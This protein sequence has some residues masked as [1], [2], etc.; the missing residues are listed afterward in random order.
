MS[1]TQ[2]LDTIKPGQKAR[3]LEVQGG[4]GLRQKLSELGIFPEQIVT[5]ATTSL[6]RGPVLVEVNSNE[7]ALGRGVAR[8]VVVEVVS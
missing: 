8:K 3:V 1:L 4:W 2:T 6:W 7:V 5:I